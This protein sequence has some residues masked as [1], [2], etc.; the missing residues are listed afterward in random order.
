MTEQAVALEKGAYNSVSE[1]VKDIDTAAEF[2][3]LINHAFNAVWWFHKWYETITPEHY[4]RFDELFVTEIHKS[5]PFKRYWLG[6]EGTWDN[7][8]KIH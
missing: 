5:E 6:P 1:G 4:E 8:E 3:Q 7:Q 2:T